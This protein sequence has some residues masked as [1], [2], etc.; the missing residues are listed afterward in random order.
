[1]TM[2]FESINEKTELSKE[3]FDKF[4]SYTKTTSLEKN[5]FL[6][7][8]GMLSKHIA[9]VKSGVLYAYSVD[10]KGDKHVV[11]L[12]LKNY[13]IGDLFSFLSGEA[14]VF[15]V[16]VIEKVELVLI[17]KENFELVCKEIPTFE[18]YF[19]ILTQNAFVN[20]QRRISGIYSSS[21]EDRYLKLIDTHPEIIQSVP[22]QYIASY[23]GIKPQS[24][25][26]IRRNI[27]RK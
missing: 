21:A 2:L 16:Q 17:S 3:N 13:W 4:L 25:S 27:H 15:N 26:R 14:S 22:Q 18:R 19:R 12:A 5:S 1:M 6:V 24:L 23:L 10:D 9:Y 11:Q 20:L 7:R 8:E